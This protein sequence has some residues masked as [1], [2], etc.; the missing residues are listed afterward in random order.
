MSFLGISVVRKLHSLLLGFSE[1]NTALCD[2]CHALYF[3]HFRTLFWVVVQVQNTGSMD[4]WLIRLPSH[5]YH[6]KKGGPLWDYSLSLQLKK[7]SD[8]LAA[9]SFKGSFDVLSGTE[10][11]IG[12]AFIVSVMMEVVKQTFQFGK[13]KME[14]IQFFFAQFV[15]L[16]WAVL[17]NIAHLLVCTKTSL[18]HRRLFTKYDT[19]QMYSDTYRTNIFT[20]KELFLCIY[21]TRLKA[22][23]MNPKPK[24]DLLSDFDRILLTLVMGNHQLL[25]RRTALALSPF[26]P[27]NIL[28]IDFRESVLMKL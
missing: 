24:G 11:L 14:N 16:W 13:N 19:F 17:R 6:R 4:A 22:R 10:T 21:W 18:W 28:L 8:S 3:G 9:S 15:A 2:W 26:S 27:P 12:N 20:S 25:G 7:A 23:R 1:A 5:N